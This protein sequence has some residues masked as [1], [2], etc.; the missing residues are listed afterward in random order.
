MIRRMLFAA[1]VLI[2]TL[3]PGFAQERIERF[4][5]DVAVQKN[6]DLIVT[7]S[8]QVWA[9]GRQIKRGILRDFPTT[10]HRA[11]GSR[12]E[13]G[14]DIQ[15][16]MRDGQ[17][18]NYTT[19]RMANGVRIRIGSANHTVN[20]GSH[21]YIIKYRTTRQIGFFQS[22]DELYWNATG[23]GWT[24]PIDVAEARIT[25]PEAVPITQSAI[26]TGPQGARGTDA[27]VIE[28]QPG[29][30]VFR[31]T[32]A[33]PVANGLTVAAGWTKGVVEQPTGMQR[34]QAILA[35]DPAFETAAI[36]GGLVIGFYL[37]A[38]LLLG[39]DPRRGTIIALFGPPNGMSAAGVR[40]VNEMGMDDRVFAAGVVGLGINH[41][42]RLFDRGGSQTLRHL[43]EGHP[44][45]AAE[46]VLET[47]LFCRGATVELEN[48]KHAVISSARSDLH[49]ALKH[50]Y[51]DLF[52][53]NSWLSGIGLIGGILATSAI[54]LAYGDSY[55]SSIGPIFAGVFF[56]LI[57]I[58]FGCNM[59][60][61]GRRLGGSRGNLRFWTGLAVT[62]IAVAAGI[63]ILGQHVGYGLA[64]APAMVPYV[65]AALGSLGFGWLKAPSREGRRIL[66][67]ID[68]F[69]RYLS[70]AEADRLEFLNPPQQTPELFQ[71]FL[72]YAIALNVE[73]SWANGFTGVLTAANLA[74]AVSPWYV[75]SDH[76]SSDNVGSNSFCRNVGSF[77]ERLGDH[78]SQTIAA[79]AVPPGS[80]SSTGSGGSSFSSDSGGGSSGGGSSGG[81]D[82]GGGGGG[83]GGSGW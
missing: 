63:Y 36:G 32:R 59:M 35:D 79:A 39:R 1:L 20:T 12:V 55:P 21:L 37:I 8:I 15:Y 19:E 6:G 2:A 42:L 17:Y 64:I 18:E 62:A 30:I 34:I 65:L 3:T 51:G 38:W 29:R 74:A 54:L 31:T 56:P 60:R 70:I 45:D 5:S 33:L 77:T 16:V 57:P 11:D 69:K 44:A 40:F 14:F 46:K 61:A 78:L 25:L 23:T 28:R 10:Y 66:D 26:Y 4:V 24:F 83:G 53:N 67:Q 22:Y 48:S 50:S 27:T 7:E 72:P 41:C 13:V 49:E 71:R 43:K 80:S 58:M 68:G 47:G 52:R 82:S 75:G 9:E 76:F 73:N 81:G